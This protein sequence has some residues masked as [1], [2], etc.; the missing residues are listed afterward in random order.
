MQ[1][2]K[3]VIGMLDVLCVIKDSNYNFIADGFYLHKNEI[4]QLVPL[5]VA[6]KMI[7]DEWD[8]SGHMPCK[9]GK[10]SNIKT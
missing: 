2:N 5:K 1:F 9:G 4:F 7:R 3:L 8:K 10:S 6:P